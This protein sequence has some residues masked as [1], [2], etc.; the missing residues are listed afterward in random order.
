MK[1][2]DL[3]TLNQVTGGL[4]KS[5]ELTT[6]LTSIQ[7]SIKDLGSN[8]QNQSSNL[9]LPVMFMAMQNRRQGPSVV[10]AG[11]ATVVA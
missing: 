9:L 11:G 10:S 3:D 4:T 8:N 7:S 5:A 1:T 2:I 6:A